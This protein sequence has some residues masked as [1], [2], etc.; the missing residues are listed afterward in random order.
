MS[1]I[2]K[3]LY[4]TAISDRLRNLQQQTPNDIYEEL[5]V[6]IHEAAHE[7]LGETPMKEKGSKATTPVEDRNIYRIVRRRVQEDIR[8]SKNLFWDKTTEQINTCAGNTR[9]NKAWKTLKSM[10]TQN[11]DRSG[12]NLISMKEWTDHFENLLTE[13]RE[14][15]MSSN[16]RTQED[17]NRHIT[18][19][20]QPEISTEDV[21]V[22]L[23]NIK[24]GKAPGIENK[25]V[26]LLRAASSGMLDVLT[27]LFNECLRGSEPPSD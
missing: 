22:A 5:K 24:N 6:I 14:E 27:Q 12:L 11:K 2:L 7:V 10:R 20:E 19:V 16:D 3:S 21:R 8:T 18:L 17:T 25:H 23:S 26:E 9:A 1:T 4:S 15:C 13:D